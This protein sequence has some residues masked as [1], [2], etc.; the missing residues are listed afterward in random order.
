MLII[1]LSLLGYFAYGGSTIVVVFKAGMV[2]WDEDLIHNSG[3][4]MET[5][6]QMGEQIGRER[7]DNDRREYLATMPQTDKPYKT[8][9]ELFARLPLPNN[10]K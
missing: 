10:V 4:S 1:G 2:K 3:N 9:N 6:V 8:I 5:L 7:N